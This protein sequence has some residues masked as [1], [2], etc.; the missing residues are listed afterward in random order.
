MDLQR[1]ITISIDSEKAFDKFQYA[2]MIKSPRE[3]GEIYFYIIE[4]IPEE[5]IAIMIINGK[6]L[7]QSH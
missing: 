7:N 4:A 5:S 3:L 6:K 1:K 2:L